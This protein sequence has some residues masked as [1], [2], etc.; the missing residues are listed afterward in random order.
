MHD[1]ATGAVTDVPWGWSAEQL[2]VPGRARSVQRALYAYADW[3]RGVSGVKDDVWVEIDDAAARA[4]QI[5][6][7]LGEFRAS[8]EG[9]D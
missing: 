8:T 9:T 2:E 5:D 4:A 6:N 7:W 3:K 1:F